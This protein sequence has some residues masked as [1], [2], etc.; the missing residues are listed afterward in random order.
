MTV[1]GCILGGAGTSYAQD[2]GA[3][4]G[5][6]VGAA[7]GAAKSQSIGDEDR[8]DEDPEG[9]GVKVESPG[10]A[11]PL[12]ERVAIA[13]KVPKGPVVDG[14][15]DDPVWDLAEDGGPLIQSDP[16]EGAQATER[17]E[18][19]IVYDDRAIYVGVWCYDR[20]P[21]K[22][23]AREMARDRRIFSD[24]WIIII[25]DTFLDRRNG[26]QFATN[27]N[28]ART[29]AL[30]TNNTGRNES[31]DTIWESR[32]T[33]D[34]EGWKAE[35]AIPFRSLSFDPDAVAWGFNI[36]RR[37]KRIGE[38]NRWSGARRHLRSY[39]ISEAGLLVGLE[40]LRQGVGL[41]VVPYVL[42]KL[43]DERRAGDT[44]T[45][46][47]G[48]FDARYRVTP[49]LTASLSYNTD[50]AETEV[51]ARQIN[52]TRFPL[53]FPE[54]RDFF[55]EDAGIFRFGGLGSSSSGRL[56]PFFSRRVG[57]SDDGDV[58]PTLVA[59]KV[60][61]RVNDYNLGVLDAVLDE[62][63][64][65]S[66]K[67]ACVTRVSRNVFDRSSV[68]MILTHGDPNS[69]NENLMAGGDFG[70]YTAELFG[71]QIFEANAF[72]LGS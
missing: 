66:V 16:D 42:S 65:L 3:V 18:F 22:I 13:V 34:D 4:A 11:E 45:E 15:L 6:V 59:G 55:L 53:F 54:K 56:L 10:G 36:H 64:G 8:D 48:G 50:F 33:I 1:V 25:F 69:D 37:V 57:L 68:G 29:D 14:R 35:V 39:T 62:H 63:T 47:T 5:G 28:G 27:P 51:D 67:N 19:R 21:S 38:T 17:T 40:G 43:R 7:G 12:G 44:D 70:Y 49:N 61:G 46:F 26:Y 72:V 32:V 9:G 20:E 2:R 23:V 58:V 30:I 71:G 24:D 60:T 31:W 41:D 52:L